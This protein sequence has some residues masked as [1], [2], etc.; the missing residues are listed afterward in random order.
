M[1][2]EWESASQCGSCNWNMCNYLNDQDDQGHDDLNVWGCQYHLDKD[3]SKEYSL[4]LGRYQ[5]RSMQ[6]KVVLVSYLSI[7]KYRIT[8][9]SYHFGPKISNIPQCCMP[10][11]RKISSAVKTMKICTHKPLR[12][13]VNPADLWTMSTSVR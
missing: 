12:S 11:I 13:S 8:D 3:L 10:D 2:D 6:W 1:N 5:K 9:V 7:L 4:V